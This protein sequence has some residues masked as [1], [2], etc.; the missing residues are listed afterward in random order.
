MLNSFRPIVVHFFALVCGLFILG[1]ASTHPGQVA[2]PLNSMGIEGLTI[3]IQN[4]T[5]DPAN[6]A[7]SLITVSLENSTG[8]W[9]RINKV[10][11]LIDKELSKVVSLV[12]G[13]DLVDWASAMDA[14]SRV[15]R[16]NKVMAQMGIASVG[17]LAAL[18]GSYR[19]D[20]STLLVGAAAITAA[21]AWALSDLINYSKDYAN[22]PDFVN[23]PNNFPKDHI[24]TPFSVPGKMFLRRW[25]LLNKPLNKKIS[26]LPLEVT[27]EN[28]T[29]ATYIVN[30]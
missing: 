8:E 24:S 7:F 27:L 4:L 1:C 11:P 10:E 5:D 15:E 26:V 28:G 2:Q 16:H 30:F 29:K 21:E 6:A 9:I 13:R 23:N 17:A 20:Q 22:H 18:T 19:N 12:K 25:F 14:S 3:S